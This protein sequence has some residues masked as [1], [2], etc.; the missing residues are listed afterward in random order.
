[1][2]LATSKVVTLEMQKEMRKNPRNVGEVGEGDAGREKKMTKNAN[3]S[4]RPTTK[5]C[6][7]VVAKDKSPSSLLLYVPRRLS[8]YSSSSLCALARS[9]PRISSGCSSTTGI[10]VELPY[11]MGTAG[12][13]V[14]SLSVLSFTLAPGGFTGRRIQCEPV[15]VHPPRPGAVL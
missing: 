12:H 7:T 15:R 1:M 6:C 9:L 8:V 5:G 4:P 2:L 3:F 14:L 10:G 13:T 11:G